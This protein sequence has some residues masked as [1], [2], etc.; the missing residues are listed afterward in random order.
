MNACQSA[1]PLT[2]SMPFIRSAQVNAGGGEPERQ[3]KRGTKSSAMLRAAALSAGATESS[4][5]T[6]STSAPFAAAFGKRSG[7]VAGV[8]SQL[9]VAN[10]CRSGAIEF[11]DLLGAARQL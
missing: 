8:N 11:I 4:K 10:C 1:S 5:S 6:M 9:R 3:A 2:E 7:R